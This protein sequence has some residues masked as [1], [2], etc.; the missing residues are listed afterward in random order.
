MRIGANRWIIVAAM[1][2]CSAEI[3]ENLSGT[4]S[5]GTGAVP[6]GADGDAGGAEIDASDGAAPPMCACDDGNPCT[7]DNCTGGMC[8][9]LPDVSA[10]ACGSGGHCHVGA[11][12]E[13]CFDLEA[14]TCIKAC[15]PGQH[16]SIF[17]T[18]ITCNTWL[19]CPATGNECLAPACLF[20]K[21]GGAP[22]ADGSPCT[23]P[24]GGICSGG[25]CV[26]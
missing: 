4:S 22:V 19:D 12:C 14:A 18:C 5:T 10:A 25:S 9:N 3:V 21:C 17:G 15:P 1:A 26:P 11:C 13:A 6:G 16:C 8:S 20:G 23:E 2:G 24:P 7:I